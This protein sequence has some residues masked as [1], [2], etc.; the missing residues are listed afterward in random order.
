KV[1]G[2]NCGISFTS[3]GRMLIQSRG[4]FLT[5]GSAFEDQF[6]MVKA[7]ANTYQAVL[8][9][10]L[11]DRYIMYGENV[12]KRHTV[13]YDALPHYFMEFDVFDKKDEC[14]LST[15]LRR[16]MFDGTPVVSVPVLHEGPVSSLEEL[17]GFIR[18]SLY[19][20]PA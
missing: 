19:K 18:P 3:T 7:W 2:A 8:W 11:G 14:F 6:N 1:D 5:G 15:E 16:I 13:F 20:T 9:S 12:Y 10:I 17:L 4:H